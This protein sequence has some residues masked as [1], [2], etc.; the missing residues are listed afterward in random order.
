MTEGQKDRETDWDNVEQRQRDRKQDMKRETECGKDTEKAWFARKK[1]Q[2][3]NENGDD[4]TL[5]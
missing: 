1:E 3:K 4:S 5:C 2:I